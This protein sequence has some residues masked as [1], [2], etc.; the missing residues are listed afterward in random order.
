MYWSK[1]DPRVVHLYCGLSFVGHFDA[2]AM[3]NHYLDFVETVELDSSMLV[4]F[5]MDGPN[6]G[7]KTKTLLFYRT[8]L[9][10]LIWRRSF[11]KIA[12]IFLSLFF[13]IFSLICLKTC[14]CCNMRNIFTLINVM[15]QSH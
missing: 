4:H 11:A 12:M 14:L 9:W 2:D 15:L 8:S 6:M 7:T 5:G 10:P 13:S 3:V 1:Q